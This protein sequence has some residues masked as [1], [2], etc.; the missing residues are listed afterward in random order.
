MK[1]LKTIF[2]VDVEVFHVLG[3]EHQRVS[4]ANSCTSCIVAGHCRSANLLFIVEDPAVQALVKA[5]FN[6]QQFN[7]GPII[8]FAQFSRY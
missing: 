7:V 1:L 4:V 6:E 3:Q 5:E 2:Q 8:I